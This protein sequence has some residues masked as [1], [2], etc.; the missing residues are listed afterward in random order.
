[1]SDVNDAHL[2]GDPDDLRKIL[3][4]LED[5]NVALDRH[6]ENMDRNNAGVLA[7]SQLVAENTAQV[8]MLRED[9]LRR[10]TA[11]ALDYK[12]RR[13]VVSVMLLGMLALFVTDQHTEHCGPGA[14]AERVIDALAAGVQDP[15]TYRALA[16]PTQTRG[17]DMT[18]PL[19]THNRS[20]WPTRW[21]LVGGLAYLCLLGAGVFWALF[22]WRRL[23]REEGRV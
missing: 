5:R 2:L 3:E 16:Q 10:P 22:A 13:A 11:T 4:A 23:K 18:F 7:L 9:V 14:R 20:N 6:S 17:C 8:K 15:S 19:H 21:N 12:R 1:M